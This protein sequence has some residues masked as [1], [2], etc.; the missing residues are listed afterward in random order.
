VFITNHALA[1]A[2]IGLVTRRPVPAFVAGVASHL[3]M[4]VCLHWGDERLDWEQFVEVGKVDGTIGLAV[5]AA[6]LA[7]APRATRVPVVAGIAGACLIDMDKP[8]LHFLGRSVF[9]AGIDGF[10]RRIQ[11]ERPI[12][13]VVEAV[14]AATLIALLAPA[15]GRARTRRHEVAQLLATSRWR[16]PAMPAAV[17]T[18]A[19][20][21]MAS[22]GTRDTPSAGTRGV[23]WNGEMSMSQLGRLSS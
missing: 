12:G 21:A 7:A 5:C 23:R 2:A 18:A 14:T 17:S 13:W 4:D 19:T 16:K 22:T 8:A 1:G 6:A 11:T 3:V 20:A 15:L 10:H 9:P